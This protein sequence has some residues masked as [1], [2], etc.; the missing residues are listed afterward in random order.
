MT[1]RFWQRDEVS[2]LGW[3]YLL[4]QKS[5]YYY[6][7]TDMDE[8]LGESTFYLEAVP[9]LLS[10]ILAFFKGWC[11]DKSE[12]YV[13]SCLTRRWH[14]KTPFDGASSHLWRWSCLV[15][16]VYLW[17]HSKWVREYILGVGRST[18]RGDTDPGKDS[19]G[20]WAVTCLLLSLGAIEVDDKRRYWFRKESIFEQWRACCSLFGSPPILCKERYSRYLLSRWRRLTAN[21]QDVG[22]HSG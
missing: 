7:K 2:I 4:S 1:S 17:D 13:P 21:P 14:E 12:I 9:F 15:S 6:R 22:I 20:V 11:D 18:K 5:F 19:I 8:L 16:N 3:R 10:Q